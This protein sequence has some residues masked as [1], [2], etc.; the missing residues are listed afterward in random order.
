MRHTRK[1][2]SL[3]IS[4]NRSKIIDQCT[5][6]R[7]FLAS[8]NNLLGHIFNWASDQHN[9]DIEILFNK[10]YTN[11]NTFNSQFAILKDCKIPN[12]KKKQNLR[13]ETNS[14]DAH[15][16][17]VLSE[18]IFDQLAFLQLLSTELYGA[19]YKELL[20]LRDEIITELNQF[21]LLLL[22]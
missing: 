14:L 19:K 2:N 1:K 22:F 18:M 6:P 9:A 17:I 8:F 13:P 11:V 7:H 3:G 12:I 15:N 20:F 4:T 5:R 16:K 21:Q 10:L